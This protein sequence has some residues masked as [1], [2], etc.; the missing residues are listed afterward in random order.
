MSY[1]DLSEKKCIGN[2]DFPAAYHGLSQKY[3]I[4]VKENVLQRKSK[5]N[6]EREF[7]KLFDVVRKRN[8][9]IPDVSEEHKAFDFLMGIASRFPSD[10]IRFFLKIGGGQNRIDCENEYM[11]KLNRLSKLSYGVRCMGWIV[12]PNTAIYHSN[13]FK[14]EYPNLVNEI[15]QLAKKSKNIRNF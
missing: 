1:P 4:P 13:H 7:W 2:C 3:D 9:I 6:S 10:G 15:I 14:N 5:C 8:K 12:S 11:K